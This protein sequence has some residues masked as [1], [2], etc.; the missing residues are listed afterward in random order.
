MNSKLNIFSLMAMYTALGNFGCK[1][2][3]D[4]ESKS[5]EEIIEENRA[6]GKIPSYKPKPLKKHQ[7]LGVRKTS[8]KRRKPCQQ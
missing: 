8:R 4:I 7:Q 2:Y 5:V 1:R 3:C 6:K